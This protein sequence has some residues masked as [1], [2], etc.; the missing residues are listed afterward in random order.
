MRMHVCVCVC[1]CVSLSNQALPN[2]VKAIGMPIARINPACLWNTKKNDWN[3][4]KPWSYGI[5]PS[6][7][8]NRMSFHTVKASSL[9]Q[10]IICTFIVFLC[11]TLVA[12]R[13]KIATVQKISSYRYS[14]E[15]LG[16]LLCIIFNTE[17]L[18]YVVD[19]TLRERIVILVKCQI[20][21]V[22]GLCSVKGHSHLCSN[23]K[24]IV[25]MTA[26][27]RQIYICELN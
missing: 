22:T 2:I 19:M 23:K 26:R 13:V 4:I 1:I 3:K 18:F 17:P 9:K 25:K 20:Y 27:A 8:N 11:Q 10:L 24:A 14:F 6:G 12:Y 15:S 5:S 21:V 16:T 7:Q